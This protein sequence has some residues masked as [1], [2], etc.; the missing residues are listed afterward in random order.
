MKV[1]ILLA[2]GLNTLIAVGQV[3]QWTDLKLFAGQSF[4][5]GNAIKVDNK[6]NFYM[7]VSS[8]NPLSS[9]GN[10]TLPEICNFIHPIRG[11]IFQGAVFRFDSTRNLDLS[12]IICKLP[13]KV[14][15]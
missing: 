3:P 14:V 5:E 7:A 8:Q 15:Q 6:G 13:Q 10:E 1:F 2:L 12:L 11:I 9:F 4:D